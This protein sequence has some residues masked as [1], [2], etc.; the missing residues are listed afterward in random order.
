MSR[1]YSFTESFVKHKRL[2][3]SYQYKAV[4]HIGT[5]LDYRSPNMGASDVGGRIREI[6][7]K[8]GLTQTQ[9]GQR[10]GVIKISVARYEAGRIPRFRILE[11]IARIGNVTVAWLL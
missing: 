5:F 8:L 1:M 11:E 3:N 7:R 6:R 10:L 9:F 4:A 2:R